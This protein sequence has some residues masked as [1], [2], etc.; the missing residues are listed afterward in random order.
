MKLQFYLRF[1][2]E[3]GQSLWLTGNTDELGNDDLARALPM[4]Y[5]DSEFWTTT[6]EVDK[7]SL[8]K[9]GFHYK[10]F[11]RTKEGDLVVEWG[12]DRIIE[13]FRKDLNEITAIDTWNHAGEYE[14]SF[15]TAPFTRVLLKYP[16]TKLKAKPSKNFTHIFKLKAPLLRKNEVVCL[17]GGNDVLRHWNEADPVLLSKDGDWWSVKIDMTGNGL[18]VAYKYGVYNTK[19]NSFVLYE[20]G[21]NRLIHDDAEKNKVTVLNDGFVHLPNDAWKGAG[22]AIPVFSLRTKTSFGVG[23]FTDIKLLVDWA[24][25]TSLSL[26]QILPINDTIATHSWLDSYPYAAISAFAL[27]PL[28][29]NLS[30]V[31]GKKHA[32]KVSALK[33]KQK[34]LNALPAVDYE[35][36]MSFKIA[37]LKE[38]YEEMGKDCFDSEDYA[39]FFEGNKHWLQP[40]AAFSFFRDKYGSSHFE[41]WKTNAYYDKEEI[42]RLFS[43]KSS[44]QKAVRYYCFVQFHLHLQLKDA[45]DYAHKKGIVLKGDIPIGIY[46]HGCDAWVAPGLYN[47]N[48]QAGA[49]PDDFTAVGQNWEFPTYNWKQMQEDG[50]GWWKQRFEQMSNYFDAFRID[51]ILGF[52]RIWTIPAHAVQGIMGRFVPCLPIHFVE[53]G[54]NG[55][56]FDDQR[57]CKPFITDTVLTEVLGNE[58]AETVRSQFLSPNKFSGYDLLPEFSTQRQVEAYFST[59][60][61]SSCNEKL[62]QGLYDLISNVIFFEQEGSRGQEFHFRISMEKT[63]SFKYLIPH[64]QHKL[65]DLYV[66]YFFRRQDDFWKKEAMHKLPHLKNATNMLVCGEDLGMVPHCVPEVMKQLGILSLE[67]QRMPKDINKE[68]FHPNDAPYLSVITPSTH[69]MSTIR[70]WWEENRERTQRFYNHAL[71]QWGDAP[72]FCESWVNRAIVLQHLYSPAMWSIFM[73]QDVL[74]MSE[75]LRR[76]NPHE[77][78]INNPAIAKHYWQYR[79]HISLEDLIREKEFNKELGEYVENSNR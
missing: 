7:K 48:E 46:R 20:K 66:N 55:I 3:F 21:D 71:G 11:L 28:Y 57:F 39:E 59:L 70:G 2:T 17:L 26:I 31:A 52:F 27:H 18:P 58:Y 64:L 22:V 73:M 75:S 32:D 25:E 13:Q 4:E 61:E 51:H 30:K 74:G 40:Y 15:F 54:E 33:K 38:L 62:K 77:E 49:P 68:F 47:M 6:I 36:V 78:R 72:Y 37:M 69:D 76:E 79:M 44:V 5:L 42:D 35:E 43:T 53:F 24:K 34:Q 50:F 8:P 10:Y 29:I 63:T 23:E 56:W 60:P 16:G 9:N 65:K 14:N 12:H 19:E 41:Q 1:H 45:A 67:I